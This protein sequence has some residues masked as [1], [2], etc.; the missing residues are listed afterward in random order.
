MLKFM[1]IIG[2]SLFNHIMVATNFVYSV[3]IKYLYL[4]SIAWTIPFPKLVKCVATKYLYQYW[5]T[6]FKFVYVYKYCVL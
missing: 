5:Y 4:Y 2:H 3:Q 6:V 1:S